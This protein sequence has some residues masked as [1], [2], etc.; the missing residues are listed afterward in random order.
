MAFKIKW[1]DEAAFEFEQI[2]N[3]IINRWT[4]KEAADFI[5]K[6]ESIIKVISTQPYLYPASNFNQIRRAVITKQTSVYYLIQ[7]EEIY[8][9]T[10]W[11][12]RQN[13]TSNPF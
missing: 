10:F 1:S 6:T 13:P 11:D 2:N 7:E 8:L 4:A 9:V 12:N 5:L 3:L